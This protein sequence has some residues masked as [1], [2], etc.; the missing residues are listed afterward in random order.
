MKPK[1]NHAIVN[2][3]IFPIAPIVV[4]PALSVL[5]KDMRHAAHY[6]PGEDR[7]E[8]EPAVALILIPLLLIVLAVV[9]SAM[10][11]LNRW[12]ARR[13]APGNWWRIV[14]GIPRVLLAAYHS[15]FFPSPPV[16]SWAT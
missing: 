5:C 12:V 1:D 3:L 4:I 7:G 11:A 14:V 16:S 2:M 10:T 6:M 8:V 15:C 13:F 9:L